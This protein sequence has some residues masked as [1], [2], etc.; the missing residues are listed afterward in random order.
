LVR[1][2]SFIK[3]FP[4]TNIWNKNDALDFGDTP[5]GRTLRALDFKP[6]L[7]SHYPHAKVVLEATKAIR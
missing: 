2:R 4:V 6:M 3:G 7:T 5:L 1:S